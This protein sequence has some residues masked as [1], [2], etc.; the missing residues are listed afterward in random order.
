[1]VFSRGS[2]EMKAMPEN[3]H[4]DSVGTG[5]ARRIG[6][7][8]AATL[9]V[10]VVLNLASYTITSPLHLLFWSPQTEIW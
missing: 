2:E 5:L 3:V 10:W 9:G 4:M 6:A 7:A 1:M 8:L